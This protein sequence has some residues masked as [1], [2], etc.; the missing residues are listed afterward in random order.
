MATAD[1]KAAQKISAAR[2]ALVLD[3]PFWGALVLRL[4]PVPTRD[5]PMGATDGTHFYYNPDYIERIPQAEVLGLAAEEVAHCAHGHMWRRAGREPERWNIACDYALAGLLRG[6]GFDTG[7]MLFDAQWEGKSAEWIYDRLPQQPPQPKGQGQGQQKGAGSGQQQGQAQGQGQGAKAQGGQPG[8]PGGPKGRCD[9]IDAPLDGPEEN[10]ETAWQ[11]AVQQ[12]ATAAKQ[13][14]TLPAGV[15]Q[16]VK[17]AVKPRVDWRSVLRRF[18]QQA[19]RADYTWLQPSRRYMARGLYMPALHSEQVGPII[20]GFDTSGSMFDPVTVAQIVS[21][22]RSI[23]EDVKP[24]RM[25]VI[26]CDATVHKVDTFEQGDLVINIAAKGGGCTAFGPAIDKA[27]ELEESPACMI[28][29]TD[30]M[31]SHR[32]QAPDFPMLWVTTNAHYS[33]YEPP[34]GEVVEVQR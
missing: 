4:T 20:I 3:Q 26:H 12:A 1:N 18:V 29:L 10:S 9:V 27:E 14:G 21:E 11:Q 24:E 30:L 32:A 15:E 16:F 23:A 13:R 5:V 8:R 19:V 17:E 2:A 31:G 25:H 33:G 28:Y 7:D 22:I 6:A 34:Y